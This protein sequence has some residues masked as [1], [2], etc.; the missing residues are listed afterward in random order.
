MKTKL[1]AF[2]L[3]IALLIQPIAYAGFDEGASAYKKGNYQAAL[4][5]F[6]PL[7]EQGNVELV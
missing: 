4:K 1:N 2:L 6:K 3:S 7:A 5:E